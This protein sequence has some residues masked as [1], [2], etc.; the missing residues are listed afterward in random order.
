MLSYWEKQSLLQYDYIIIGSGI[1][2]LSTA[3][4]IRERDEKGRILVLEREV[5]P[6]G[7]STKNAGFACIGSL[8]EILADLK[9]M[10]PGE[11]QSL[12]ALRRRG[13]LGLRARIGDACMDYR[14]Q[15]SF[16]LIS[17]KELPALA[18]L[19]EVNR[20]LQPVLDGAAFSL[21]T[22]K[23]A[24]FGFDGSYVK[25]LVSN[26]YEGE[27]NTG[28]MIRT[29]IDLA[30]VQSIEIKTGC[31]VVRI[32][33]TGKGAT[34]VVRHETL[35][36]EIGFSCRELVV[37]T[38]AFGKEL[39]PELDIQPGRGQ[40]L[41]TEPVPDL[42][43]RGIFH[44]D[45]GYFYFRELHGRVLFGGGR[46]LDMQA[47]ETTIFAYN[48]HLQGILEEKLR[49]ILLPGREVR[50]ADRWTGIMAFGPNRQ[51]LVQRYSEHICI[52]VRLGGMGVAIGTAVG[53]QLA[54]ML[55]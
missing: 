45:E 13:L 32:A 35:Q 1:V 52:G 28:K 55:R 18:Q 40:V 29:L 27:L 16:E 39:L 31:P 2:G 26:N 22:P 36:E 43:F 5:L 24:G 47:E 42:P 46:H 7:A 54:D 37:C 23:L 12:V 11:V 48:D 6:T 30:I 21:A 41:L 17:D 38:N 3:I 53:Q 50:I 49:T 25:A 34:V 51:P 9:T 44:M 33:D 14:E 20:L 10:S 8:T 4:S 15:G 19:D